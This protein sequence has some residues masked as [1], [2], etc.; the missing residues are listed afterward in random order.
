[1][2]PSL[3]GRTTIP[4]QVQVLECLPFSLIPMAIGCALASTLNLFSKV[5]KENGELVIMKDGRE[6]PVV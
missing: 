2:D 5:K 1:M 4:T 3:L 6:S